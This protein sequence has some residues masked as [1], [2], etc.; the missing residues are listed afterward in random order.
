MIKKQKKNKIHVKNGDIVQII[1]VLYSSKYQIR[2]RYHINI[3][4]SKKC[5]QLN[6][7]QEVIE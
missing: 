7:T 5:R 3:S 6:K 2:S 4:A 1:S